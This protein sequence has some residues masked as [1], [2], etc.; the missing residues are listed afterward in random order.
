MDRIAD[1]WMGTISELSRALIDCIA[2]IWVGTSSQLSRAVIDCI[3]DIWVHWYELSAL[4]ERIADILMGTRSKISWTAF[5]TFG[6]VN[7][8]GFHGLRC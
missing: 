8:L 3:A 4:M 6:L 7:A 1:I 2:D 5:L